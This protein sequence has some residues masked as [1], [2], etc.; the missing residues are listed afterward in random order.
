MTML[1]SSGVLDSSL[2]FSFAELAGS[3]VCAKIRLLVQ[4]PS[5][6]KLVAEPGFASLGFQIQKSLR[7]EAHA[8]RKRKGTVSSTLSGS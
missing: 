8:G 7:P 4:Y 1:T 5:A 3:V 6:R 2:F